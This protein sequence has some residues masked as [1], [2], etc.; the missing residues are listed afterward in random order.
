MPL[1]N[2]AGKRAY[3]QV[4]WIDRLRRRVAGV[5]IDKKE[6]EGAVRKIGDEGKKGL[7]QLR[8]RLGSDRADGGAGK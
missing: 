8:E 4:T 6:I 5:S 1:E 7:L 3:A 2:Q